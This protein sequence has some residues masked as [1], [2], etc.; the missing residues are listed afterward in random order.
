[1]TA[2]H[3]LYA[4]FLKGGE[5]THVVYHMQ[6]RPLTATFSDGVR[7]TAK[8]RG[9]AIVTARRQAP[10]GLDAHAGAARMAEP[11]ESKRRSRSSAAT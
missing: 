6:D 10:R 7:V 2:D 1:V 3:P 5:R 4:V 8:G 11:C 9:F